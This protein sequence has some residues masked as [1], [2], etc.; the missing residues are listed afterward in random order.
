MNVLTNVI[1][2]HTVQSYKKKT[3]SMKSAELDFFHIFRQI[4]P[5]F[6]KFLSLNMQIRQLRKYP[7]NSL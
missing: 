6:A 1:H 4:C 7:L 5:V 2:F 3:N